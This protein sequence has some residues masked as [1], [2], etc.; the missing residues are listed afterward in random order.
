MAGGH[1]RAGPGMRR[2]HSPRLAPRRSRLRAAPTVGGRLRP[3]CPPAGR[4]RGRSRARA[5]LVPHVTGIPA[6]PAH[7]RLE[8][9]HTARLAPAP[10]QGLLFPLGKRERGSASP[11]SW[12]FLT[13]DGAEDPGGRAVLCHKGSLLP[14]SQ[15]LGLGGHVLPGG[16][17]LQLPG[18]KQPKP[19]NQI[20][21]ARLGRG[22]RAGRWARG[23]SAPASGCAHIP[24]YTTGHA[25]KI[26][27]SPTLGYRAATPHF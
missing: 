17:G 24:P 25:A 5:V 1:G 6:H 2:P 14:E 12:G 15:Q 10:K 21:G 3:A 23:A 18:A 22:G 26:G 16:P 19:G 8:G 11:Q 7:P 27:P 20:R 4:K 13:L 9:R